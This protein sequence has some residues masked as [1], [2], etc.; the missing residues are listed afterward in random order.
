MRRFGRFVVRKRVHCCGAADAPDRSGLRRRPVALNRSIRNRWKRSA[1]T[2]VAHQLNQVAAA[3]VPERDRRSSEIHLVAVKR[4]Q[5]RRAWSLAAR[6]RSASWIVG[7]FMW[8]VS[9]RR[10]ANTKP[11]STSTVMHA[12]VAMTGHCTR[13]ECIMMPQQST[14]PPTMPA[15]AVGPLPAATEPMSEHAEHDSRAASWPRR[16]LGVNILAGAGVQHACRA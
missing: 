10:A 11:S 7:T 12:M 15:D 9:P 8:V 13:E 5:S 14:R 16:R 2:S 3:S 6:A 1:V 4:R